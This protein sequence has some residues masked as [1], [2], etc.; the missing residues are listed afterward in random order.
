MTELLRQRDCSGLDRLGRA[1]ADPTR[2]SVLLELLAG[3]ACPSE[4]AERLGTTRPNL[5]NHLAC[6]RGCGL[7]EATRTGRHLHYR[8]IN[9]E[10]A[11]LLRS[12]AHFGA[13]LRVGD[14][15]CP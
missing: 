8:L 6:L 1:L 5:S 9:D 10:L 4:L 3:P 12:L 11:A 14:P 13:T 15:H 2:R 7:I